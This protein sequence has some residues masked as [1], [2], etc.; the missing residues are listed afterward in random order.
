MRDAQRL[1]DELKQ[2]QTTAIVEWMSVVLR[3]WRGERAAAEEGAERL[4]AV[5]VLHGFMQW[6]DL[7]IV[8]APARAA[9]LDADALAERHERL[10]KSPTAIWRR[11]ICLCHLTQLCLEAGAIDLGRRIMAS[12]GGEH[13]GAF[14]APEIERLEGELCLGGA[15]PDD[16]EAHFRAAIDLARRRQEKSLEL[17]ATTSLARLLA[18]QGR[19]DAAHTS[20]AAIHG[21]F[22]E[23]FET[24]DLRAASRL[25]RE[26]ATT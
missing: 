18:A 25:L 16:A 3:L 22:T 20:L 5:A 2:A 12:I 1:A 14:L 23:G 4:M 17:R 7:G 26:L 8:V 19:H 11:V 21:W 6:T 9:T 10:I 13:R 15:Q 24:A